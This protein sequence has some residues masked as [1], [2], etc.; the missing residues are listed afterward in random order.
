MKRA[1]WVF[2][3]ETRE[4]FR[5]KRVRTGAFVMPIFLVAVFVMIFGLVEDSVTKKE[6][7]SFAVVG[8]SLDKATDQL[9]R[10]L[11]KEVVFVA[12]REEGKELLE[13]GKV[14]LVLDFGKGIGSI[15]PKGQIEVLAVY[16]PTA[17]LSQIALGTIDSSIEKLNKEVL[18]V[19][20][21]SSGL[22]T[23]VAETIKL[24]SVEAEKP[25][26]L[27]GSAL[28]GMLPYLIVLWAFSGGISIVADMVAGEKEKG[29]METLLV[30]PVKR[31]EVAIGKFLALAL[32]CFTSSAMSLI[33]ILLV[34]LIKPGSTKSLFPTGVAVSFPS[35]VAMVLAIVPLVL[36]SSGLLL[37]VSAA[38]KNMREAQTY[39]TIVNF[40][41]IMPAVF[42]QI[43]GFTG[44]QNALWVKCV[45]ILGNAVCL[46]EALLSKTDW[47]GLGLCVASC[48]LLAAVFLVVAVKMFEREQI[49]ARS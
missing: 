5:D 19:Q 28:A 22:S 46:R 44:M 14:R 42:S 27:G 18:K 20:L 9:V 23:T 11:A 13:K 15:D 3:K 32:V 38:A 39:L 34:G 48:S 43:L 40:A 6:K 16:D 25:K 36:F 17:P 1:L 41:V 26:G 45:P 31:R 37:T 7:Q 33:G 35:V 10:A 8:K 29:T 30:S 47:G 21:K 2:V 4:T 24:T 49:L 12:T